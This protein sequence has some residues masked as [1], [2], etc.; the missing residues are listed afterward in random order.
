MKSDLY[1]TKPFICFPIEAQP[2]TIDVLI[3]LKIGLSHE[4]F[5]YCL[6]FIVCPNKTMLSFI[7][8]FENYSKNRM[9]L[10]IICALF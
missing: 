3:S 6:D 4:F 5:N 7:T 1:A 10:F 9:N 2:I 8:K